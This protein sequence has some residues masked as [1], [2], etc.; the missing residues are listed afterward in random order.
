[1]SRLGTQEGPRWLVSVAVK[2]SY[3]LNAQLNPSMEPFGPEAEP[4]WASSETWRE[5]RERRRKALSLQK[6]LLTRLATD[7][8][9]PVSRR[10]GPCIIGTKILKY[11]ESFA[12]VLENV[13][14][15]LKVGCGQNSSLSS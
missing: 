4:V 7:A 10:C 5:R 9:M 12:D 8:L 2:Y 6:V 14:S 11:M 3:A 13:T 1:M 15:N